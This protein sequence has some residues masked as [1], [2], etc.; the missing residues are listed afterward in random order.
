MIGPGDEIVHIKWLARATA[1]S[2]LY[3][4]AHVSAWSQRFKPEAMQQLRDK[5][6]ATAPAPADRRTSEDR[7]AGHRRT[8]VECGSA[9]HAVSGQYT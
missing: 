5:V 7:G 8:L 2:H 3:T 9:V 1:A 4:Q 6:R